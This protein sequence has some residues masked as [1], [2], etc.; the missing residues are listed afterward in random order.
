MLYTEA[1]VC[2][3]MFYSQRGE[4]HQLL[5]TQCTF[6]FSS[7]LVFD[8]T[9]EGQCLPLKIKI[10]RFPCS[11]EFPM[12]QVWTM[13]LQRKPPRKT[14]VFLMRHYTFLAITSFFLVILGI[15][16]WC[17]EIQELSYDNEDKGHTYQS[18]KKERRL[19]DLL[20]LRTPTP[21]LRRPPTDFFHLLKDTPLFD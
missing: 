14:F 6:A 8:L 4:F 17:L 20:D 15:W 2:L 10:P 12:I 11:Q 13:N 21:A 5:P 16:L 9:E 19:R 18:N 7:S 1:K 3:R